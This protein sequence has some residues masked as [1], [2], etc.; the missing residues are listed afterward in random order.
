[1]GQGHLLRQIRRL[2]MALH[3][4]TLQCGQDLVAPSADPGHTLAR[5]PDQVIQSLR[6]QRPSPSV[7]QLRVRVQLSLL[8]V[9]D[10]GPPTTNTTPV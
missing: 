10:H 1:M 6:H 9:L 7:I 4:H 3:I 2:A 5:G 8:D